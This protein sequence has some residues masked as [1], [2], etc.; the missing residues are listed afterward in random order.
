MCTTFC[1]MIQNHKL[2]LILAKKVGK[3]ILK[4]M[5]IP[6]IVTDYYNIY[7]IDNFMFVKLTIICII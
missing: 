1:L 4:C 5:C 3:N 7:F 6:F 2:T